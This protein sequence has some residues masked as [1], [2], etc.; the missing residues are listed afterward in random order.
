MSARPR[1]EPRP[2][3]KPTTLDPYRGL[4]TWVDIYDTGVWA[5]PEGAVAAI[6]ARGART[7]YLETSN[8]SQA[9]PIR[10]PALVARFL[11]AAHA[12]GLAVVAWYLPGFLDVARDV[13]RSLAAISF[14]TMSGQTFDGF[15]LDIESPAVRS[16]SYGRAVC[17]ASR[18]TFAKP[19]AQTTASVPSSPPRAVSSSRRRPGP[20][21]PTQTLRSASTSSCR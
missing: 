15:G 1:L 5:D 18:P 21:S 17:C 3:R 19:S 8:Y 10:R 7:V 13:R 9:V 14:T 2:L 6:A 16:R 12:Q 4:G 20:A 11:E